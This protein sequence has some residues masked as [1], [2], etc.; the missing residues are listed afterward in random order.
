[1]SV[2]FG[3][4]VFVCRF[5]CGAAIAKSVFWSANDRTIFVIVT[6]VERFVCL[7]GLAAP[8][9]CGLA[10]FD[11]AGGPCT[12]GPVGAVVSACGCVARL[13]FALGVVGGAVAGAGVWDEGRAVWV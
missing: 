3:S 7:D 12:G 4:V 6:K 9:A 10:G 2:R 5:A 8:P 1:M 13:L 11:E